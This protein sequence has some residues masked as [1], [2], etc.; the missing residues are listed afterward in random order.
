MGV[1]WDLL[2]VTVRGSNGGIRL[3]SIDGRV[4]GDILGDVDIIIIGIDLGT[5]MGSFYAPLMVILMARLRD[6]GL[7]FHWDLLMLKFLDMMKA[8][9]YT[10][11]LHIH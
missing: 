8:C 10:Y 9:C 3:G 5:Y 7:K 6:Y 4:L 1:H 11:P 2:L